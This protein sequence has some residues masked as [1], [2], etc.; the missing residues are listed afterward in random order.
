MQDSSSPDP[1]HR[2]D[3]DDADPRLAPLLAWRQQ[4]IDSGAVAA[5]SFKEAHLRL[6]LRSGRT[7]VEQIRA[8]LPGSVAEHADEMARV[9]SELDTS[10][11]EQ[12]SITG[13]HR[14]TDASA[15]A[16]LPSPT[17]P[18]AGTSGTLPPSTPA[19]PSEPAPPAAPA[20]PPAEPAPVAE[21][22]LTAADFTPFT[23][24]QQQSP[25]QSIALRRNAAGGAMEISWPPLQGSDG[26]APIWWP[27]P[28][29]RRRPTPA[30]PARRSGITRSGSTSAPPVPR[31]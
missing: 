20:P 22:P 6:V 10:S 4:L 25:R 29:R 8:M 19:V 27:P 23:F 14:T 17:L 21:S 2:E 12:T 11:T 24:R 7:D 9:L 1:F 18:P 5:R 30:H 31:P 16:A 28:I 15:G 26:I 13:R 3:P